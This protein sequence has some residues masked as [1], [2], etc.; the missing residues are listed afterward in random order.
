MP[1]VAH[2]LEVSDGTSANVLTDPEKAFEMHYNRAS[3]VFE[4]GLLGNPLFELPS[5]IELSARMPDH[6]DTYWS[7][8][9]VAVNKG[10]SAGTENRSSLQ[11]TILHIEHNDSLVILKHTE[12]DPVYG[13]VLQ[14]FLTRL[15]KLSG[16]RMRCDV[17]VGEALI[18]ISSP[19][20]I[21]PYHMDGE[22]NFLVQVVGDKMFYVFPHDD[23]TLVTNDDLERYYLKDANS[24]IYKA[25]RQKDAV[26]YDLRA[27][28]GVH[29]PVTA[30]HW[31]QNMNNISVAISFTYELRSVDRLAKIYRLNHQLRRLGFEPTPPGVSPW[32][33]RLKAAT[34][35][36]LADLRAAAKPEARFRA[37]PAWTPPAI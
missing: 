6:R 24:A 1:S 37:F 36:T 11:D 15:V 22:A 7:N 14:N 34:A 5:L 13:P 30:P 18:L 12:Q 32:R 2:L 23:L 9:Q 16:E 26:A 21:T 33:D 20:R 29:V 31:V 4:H 27:G 17:T 28:M 25:D 3:F 8:G 19:N 10:W 35:R